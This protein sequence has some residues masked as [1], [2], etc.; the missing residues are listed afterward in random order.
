VKYWPLGVAALLGLIAGWAVFH[1]RTD[2]LAQERADSLAAARQHLVAAEV[3]RARDDST[4]RDSISR[5]RNAVGRASLVASRLSRRA[6]SLAA[7]L[8]SVLGGVR[9][10]AFDSLMAVTDSVHKADSAQI[11]SLQSAL[12]IAERRWYIA[13]SAAVQWRTLQEGTALQLRDAL[14]RGN[15]RCI[16]GPSATVGLHGYAL[17]AGVTC[18]I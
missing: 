13:D 4:A 12:A 11:T 9:L 15:P 6:D 8:R 1:P 3:A 10:A 7:D 16:L 18:R 2:P 5:L 14:K 17:G